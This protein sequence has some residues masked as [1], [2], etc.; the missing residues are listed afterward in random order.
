MMY[1]KKL[2]NRKTNTEIKVFLRPPNFQSSEGK[3]KISHS[4]DSPRYGN[5]ASKE[6]IL[7]IFVPGF[8]SYNLVINKIT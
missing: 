4:W 1:K 7:D 6:L 3:P 5:S 2:K 8:Y